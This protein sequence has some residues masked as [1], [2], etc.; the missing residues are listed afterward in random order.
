[1]TDEI[2]LRQERSTLVWFRFGHRQ[3][4]PFQ[5]QGEHSC[6]SWCPFFDIVDGGSPD[7]TTRIAL[8]CSPCVERIFV[9]TADER[10][11]HDAA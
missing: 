1:M 7:P 8:Y 11:K 3:I 9:V 5:T 6:G 2:V 4:C 10:V